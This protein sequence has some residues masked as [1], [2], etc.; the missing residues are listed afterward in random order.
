[1]A[2][3]VVIAA[4]IPTF[5]AYVRRNRPRTS[6]PADIPGDVLRATQAEA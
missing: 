1:M 5:V 4:M 3:L 6:R 2:K